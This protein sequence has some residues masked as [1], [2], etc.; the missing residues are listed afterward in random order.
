MLLN[1]RRT[2]FLEKMLRHE[3]LY[4]DSFVYLLF[5]PPFLTPL[6]LVEDTEMWAV[7]G[8]DEVEPLCF[9][10]AL[11][12]ASNLAASFSVPAPAPWAPD[13]FPLP[14]R[15]RRLCDRWFL[16]IHL[17]GSGFVGLSGL[18]FPSAWSLA[19]YASRFFARWCNRCSIFF[20]LVFLTLLFE[21]ES[22]TKVQNLRWAPRQYKKCSFQLLH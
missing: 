18:Y 10:A 5:L 16:G 21:K 22:K 9:A 14:F 7:L 15:E 8:A 11:A 3:K 2:N 20:D 17:S 19:R 12:A 1:G 4:L 13:I 6:P